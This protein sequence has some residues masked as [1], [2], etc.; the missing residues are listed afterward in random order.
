MKRTR[1]A[2][3]PTGLLHLGNVYSALTCEQWAKEHDTQLLL[4]VEDIDF[5]RCKPTHT[6]QLQHDL[7]WLGIHFHA[8]SFQQQRLALY[9]KVLQQLIDMEVLY[10]CF[11]T[12][13]QVDAALHAQSESKL[14]TLH[15]RLDVYP[16]TCKLLAMQQR[17]QKMLEQTYAWRLNAAVVSEMIGQY[18]VWYDTQG[19]AQNFKVLDIGDVIIGRKD[20]RFSYHL[21]VVVDDAIQGISHVIRGEDL[22]SSTPVHRVLQLLL[23]YDSPAYL[24]HKLITNQEGTRL[25][26]SKAS[27]T[28]KSLRDS[29]V[30]AKQIRQSLGF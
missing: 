9:E 13:K 14:N 26:K 4:R 15:Q 1:F 12:R 18:C 10:P 19:V 11:C 6:E 7:A 8:V 30:T 5:T 28:L 29:G 25:A 24:H 22:R 23:G 2:P 17:Q 16:G 21:C 3:S 20:I 27:P